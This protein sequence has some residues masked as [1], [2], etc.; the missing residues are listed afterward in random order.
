MQA[1]CACYTQKTN[2]SKQSGSQTEYSH[3]HN[4]NSPPCQKPQPTIRYWQY[5][6]RE[7]LFIP[8]FQRKSK[9]LLFLILVLIDKPLH[10]SKVIR[11]CKIAKLADHNR[12]GNT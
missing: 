8:V 5:M 6:G 4:K 1:D 10:N 2:R 3:Y 11:P 9:N 7:K 12:N